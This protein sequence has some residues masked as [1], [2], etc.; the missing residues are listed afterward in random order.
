MGWYGPDWSGSGEGLVEGS[1]QYGNEPS[2][3]LKCWEILE[4]LS[5]WWLL[6]HSPP[7]SYK[8]L[9]VYDDGTLVQ[10]LCIW[11]LSIILFIFQN[12]MFQ[13]LDS[14]CLLVKSTQA[15]TIE[16][17]PISG[18]TVVRR[19]WE[20]SHKYILP[21]NHFCCWKAINSPHYWQDFYFTDL[22]HQIIRHQY[23]TNNY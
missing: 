8:D 22:I 19:S 15:Q 16:L 11:T 23:K 1:F 3:S 14:L 13:R 5:N 10:I 4:W 17:V 7:R 21:W 12:T 9:K 6:K 2:A 18:P 20:I